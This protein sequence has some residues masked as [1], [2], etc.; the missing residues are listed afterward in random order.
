MNLPEV[1]VQF[2]PTAAA[3]QQ[4]ALLVSTVGKLG[5][6]FYLTG[7]R[8]LMAAALNQALVAG[9]IPHTEPH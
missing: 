5:P 6:G 4:G 9:V 2:G 3:H 8:V 1:F 7:L